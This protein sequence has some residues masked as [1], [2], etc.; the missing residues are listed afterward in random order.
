MER[1]HLLQSRA[2]ALA[3][4]CVCLRARALTLSV[5]HLATLLRYTL[6]FADNALD[7][8]TG[9]RDGAA[10][11]VELHLLVRARAL[12]CLVLLDPCELAA[13]SSIV[14]PALRLAENAMAGRDCLPDVFAAQMVR[15]VVVS[16]A[17][18]PASPKPTTGSKLGVWA[19]EADVGVTSLLAPSVGKMDESDG[20]LRELDWAQIVLGD[21]PGAV[22][23]TRVVDAGVQ[24][25]GHVFPHLGKTQQL[26]I[27]DALVT[28]PNLLAFNSH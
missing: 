5:S 1:K 17:A 9:S 28:Q 3:H 20:M 27:L 4:M 21:A 12:E 8:P 2:L 16:E 18:H 22:A 26:A 15:A 25:M 6:L 7:A 24:V 10:Q 11:L 13:C 19:Y 23:A 14:Q